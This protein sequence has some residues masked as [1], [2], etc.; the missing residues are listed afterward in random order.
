MLGVELCFPQ[1]IGWSPNFTP[2]NAAVCANKVV[3]GAMSRWC[4]NRAGLYS[5][6]SGILVKR[7]NPDTGS[8]MGETPRED[9]GKDRGDVPTS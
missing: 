4:W 1:F 2:Q 5:N 7:G 8:H 3:A 6:I 9:E